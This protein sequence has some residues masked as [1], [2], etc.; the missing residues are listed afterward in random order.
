MW[1]S[2]ATRP[3]PHS[4]FARR[5]QPLRYEHMVADTTACYDSPVASVPLPGVVASVAS[6]VRVRFDLRSDF[7]FPP[8][9]F[10]FFLFFPFFLRPAL[11]RRESRVVG[12]SRT[13]RPGRPARI[14][15]N[16]LENV[17]RENAT[18]KDGTIRSTRTLYNFLGTPLVT[19][20]V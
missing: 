3:A 12:G 4:R 1:Q 19:I 7:F 13:Q 18:E 9:F 11:R 8:F 16:A 10:V 15:T 5:S 20:S 6:N 17:A 14:A 2:A